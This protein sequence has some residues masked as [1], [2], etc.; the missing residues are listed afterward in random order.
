MHRIF[1]SAL[2]LIITF[3]FS[4]TSAAEKAQTIVDRAVRQYEASASLTAA[5][6]IA[7]NN[8]SSVKATVI[9]SRERFKFDSA[10]MKIWFD[11]RTQWTYIP[12]QKEIDI[13]EPT[14]DELAQINPFT[15][16]SAL[17]SKFAYSLVSSGSKGNT[18][19]FTSLHDAATSFTVT[20]SQSTGWPDMIV[21]KAT[22]GTEV[23]IRISGITAGKSLNEST[24]RM[25]TKTY[26]G[27]E[28]VDLR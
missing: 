26:K 2:F 5:L 9:M 24:F 19:R 27:V 21:M 18:I 1:A 6:T 7:S 12:Q 16:I 20:F 28:I 10:D 22:D 11:G 14:A 15:V 3:I 25:N 13:T 4:A 8:S 17:R 23:K